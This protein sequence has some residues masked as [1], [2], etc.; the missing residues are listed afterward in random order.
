MTRLLLLHGFTGSP[1]SF[2]SIA[3]G[4]PPRF[5]IVAPALVGH[6]GSVAGSDVTS[7][8]AEV[9]R[10]AA[11]VGEGP[12]AHLAGYSL[13]ARLGLALLARFPERFSRATLIGVHPGLMDENERARRREGDARWCALLESRGVNAFVEAW[14]AQPLFATQAR[15]PEP[16]L[17]AQAAER[18]AHSPAGLA[19]SLRVTGLAEMP[20]LRPELGRIRAEVTLLAGELD[21]KFAALGR[22][23]SE[24]LPRCRLR[25]AP[26]AGHNLLLEAPELVTHSI[27]R[28][29]D[30]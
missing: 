17:R 21:E 22:E 30:P 13:G 7:F 20:D 4:L 24:L 29:L 6:A 26:G 23:L 28:G 5:E 18:L 19:T 10:L 25:L 11:L 3:S 14:Q 1:H 12:P 27:L 15:L 16:V 2:S 8:A 9:R